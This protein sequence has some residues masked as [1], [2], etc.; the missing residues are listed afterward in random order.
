M[1]KE[2]ELLESIPPAP[3]DALWDYEVPYSMASDHVHATSMTVDELLP[4][5]G[6]PFRISVVTNDSLIANA[7]FTS[8]AWLFKIA[9]RVDSFRKLDLASQIDRI[10]RPYGKIAKSPVATSRS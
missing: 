7:A 6:K 1:A 5:A 10:F 8:T 9:L 3:S 4:E 2:K